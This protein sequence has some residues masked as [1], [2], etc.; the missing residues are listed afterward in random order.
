MF[1]KKKL[2][3]SNLL[4]LGGFFVFLLLV[5]LGLFLYFLNLRAPDLAIQEEKPFVVSSGESLRSIANRLEQSGLIRGSW[6]FIILAYQQN[7]DRKIQAGEFRLS[8]SMSA[9]EIVGKLTSGSLDTWVTII[10]GSRSEEVALTLKERL[11]GFDEIWFENLKASEGYLMPDSYLVPKNAS[12]IDFWQIVS[13]NYQRKVNK[14]VL[15]KA[16]SRGLGEEEL[17][18]FASLVEREAKSLV[19]QQAVAGVLL[20][21]IRNG[22]PLQVDASVQYALANKSCQRDYPAQCVWWPKITGQDTRKM[23]SAY[24]TYQNGGFP[25]GP[26][27]N[28]SPGAIEAVAGAPEDSP[29]WYYISDSSGKLHLAITLAE[30]EENINRYLR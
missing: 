30:H 10:P 20:N 29:Y 8:T 23:I 2:F 15:A 22:W 24:N 19:D 21:R 14:E 11:S 13:K 16:Q 5:F 27:C 4:F 1:F 17:I 26:I 28:P 9:R 25:P 6:A 3:G 18:I 7:L 12:W